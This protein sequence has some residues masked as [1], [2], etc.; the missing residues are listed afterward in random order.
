MGK[1]WTPRPTAIRV[2]INRPAEESAPI[3]F[4][5]G[6]MVLIEGAGNELHVERLE[7]YGLDDVVL[8]CT[9]GP[10][11]GMRVDFDLDVPQQVMLA[12]YLIDNLKDHSP[13]EFARLI[14]GYFPVRE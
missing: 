11:D 13:F 8:Q 5:V 4:R 7:Q 2:Q 6:P 10:P 12:Q 9:S 14:D 3:T 1:M